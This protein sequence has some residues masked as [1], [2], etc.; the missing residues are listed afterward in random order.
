[1]YANEVDIAPINAINTVNLSILIFKLN[2]CVGF[3]IRKIPIHPRINAIM[4]F[5]LSFH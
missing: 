1:M 4:Y 5:L 2:N 3:T